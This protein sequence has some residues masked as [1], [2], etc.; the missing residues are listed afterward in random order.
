M[1]RVT[2]S[3]ACLGSG[4]YNPF[5]LIFLLGQLPWVARIA[6]TDE[7]ALWPDGGFYV[8]VVTLLTSMK[9]IIA[10]LV[11]EVKRY[12]VISLIP[13]CKR[14][15]PKQN[16]ELVTSISASFRVLRHHSNMALRDVLTR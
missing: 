15:I 11:Q 6:R 14:M 9:L 12:V 1:S 4:S 5:D 2:G 7:L 3:C 13:F 8:L 16:I 10:L